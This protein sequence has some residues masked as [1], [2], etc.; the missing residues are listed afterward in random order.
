MK[1]TPLQNLPYGNQAGKLVSGAFLDLK[2]HPGILREW[3]QSGDP[4][5]YSLLRAHWVASGRSRGGGCCHGSI[6]HSG[7]LVTL[8][9]EGAGFA[10]WLCSPGK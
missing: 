4:G 1:K 10:G 7:S 5:L 2:G 3:I 9:S 6:S 8:E